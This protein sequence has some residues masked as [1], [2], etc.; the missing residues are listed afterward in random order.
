MRIAIRRERRRR[1]GTDHPGFKNPHDWPPFFDRL[2]RLTH[3]LALTHKTD[4]PH[5]ILVSSDQFL[6]H[7]FRFA[8]YPLSNGWVTSTLDNALDL[9]PKA[10]GVQLLVDIYYTDAPAIET[11]DRL[12]RIS[13]EYPQNYIHLIAPTQDKKAL[14]FMKAVT[15][16]RIISRHS[17]FRTLRK[18]LLMPQPIQFNRKSHFSRDEWLIL[19]A[20]TQGRSLKSIASDHDKDYHRIIY[21]LG[22]I[23][24]RLKLQ[25]RSELIH[26]LQNLSASSN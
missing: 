22:R 9:L 18:K 16:L 26:L 19:M 24:E 2:E 7:G 5:F 10:P 20:L 13:F 14:R 11:L 15:A 3:S 8:P 21:R 6:R 17:P 1:S 25:H 12:R 4:S 23:V